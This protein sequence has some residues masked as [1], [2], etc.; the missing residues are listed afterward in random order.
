MLQHK[1]SPEGY[2]VPGEDHVTMKF[3]KGDNFVKTVRGVKVLN[4][5]TLSDNALYLYQVLPKH[6]KGL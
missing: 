5:C 1:N 4:L 2:V 6:L 3:T